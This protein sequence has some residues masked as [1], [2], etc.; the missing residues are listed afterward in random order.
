[1]EILITNECPGIKV[2]T[3]EIK[4]QIGKIL[5][6]LDCKDHEISILFTGDQGIRELNHQF[7]GIDRPTDVLSFPQLAEGEPE[8]PGAPV[9]GDVAISLET[10][11]HQSEDHGLSLE[12]EQTLLLIHGILHLL[13]YDH[14]VSGQ[15]EERMRKKTRELFAIIYPGKKLADTCNF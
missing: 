11:R 5:D 15:E 1:M 7:R 3:R 8:P 9:L 13:G 14:E 12:E 6:S 2:N 4:L 10:A